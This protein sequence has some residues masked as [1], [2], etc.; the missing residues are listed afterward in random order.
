MNVHIAD[1]T[2]SGQLY[3]RFHGTVISASTGIDKRPSP[4]GFDRV[5]RSVGS[6]ISCVM[7]CHRRRA[8]HPGPSDVVGLN[9][10][11]IVGVVHRWGRG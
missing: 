10:N 2:F 8:K 11:K 5:D 9:G 4:N 7:K 3:R 6:T 1:R